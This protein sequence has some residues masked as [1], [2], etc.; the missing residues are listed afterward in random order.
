MV[1]R[2]PSVCPLRCGVAGGVYT[3]ALLIRQPTCHL[4]L[5]E[6]HMVIAR[7][8]TGFAE[9]ETGEEIAKK[10]R[11]HPTGATQAH[12]G[13]RP[14]SM[15]QAHGTAGGAGRSRLKRCPACHGREAAGCVSFLPLSRHIPQLIPPLV[16]RAPRH[17]DLI[18]YGLRA[19]RACAEGNHGRLLGFRRQLL[20]S[21]D[22]ARGPGCCSWSQADS[23]DL[24]G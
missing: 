4:E 3:L 13:R 1:P 23:K 6:K 16:Q 19:G 24:Q 18:G 10:T 21:T 12:A 9:G 7:S 5:E 17:S 15:G 8:H 2:P 14:A 22:H 11:G 20:R